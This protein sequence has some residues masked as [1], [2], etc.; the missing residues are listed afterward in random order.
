[1]ERKAIRLFEHKGERVSR[2]IDLYLNEDGSMKVS[3]GDVGR[4]VKGN[5]GSSDYEFWVTIAPENI[6]HLCFAL[7]RDKLADDPSA[8]DHLRD[9]CEAEGIKNEFGVWR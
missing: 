4:A 8:V 5:F 2:S 7:L 1:M 3:G 9:Y 6:G